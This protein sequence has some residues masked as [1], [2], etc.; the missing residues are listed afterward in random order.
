MYINSCQMRCEDYE[1][2]IN[3]GREGSTHGL[4]EGWNLTGCTKVC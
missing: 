3:S 1:S 2:N 4:L